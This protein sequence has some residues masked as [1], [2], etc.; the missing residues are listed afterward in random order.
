MRTPVLTSALIT[1]VLLS[2]LALGGCN[3]TAAP[4]APLPGAYRSAIT[5]PGFKLPEGTGCAGEIAR[6]RAVIGNDKRGGQVN[7]KVYDVITREIDGA[8]AS[9]S[10]GNE[11][12]AMNLVRASKSR[13][14]YPG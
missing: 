6:Y 1:G 3:T 11:A 7:D 5:P 2:S 13:H 8:S 4:P 12:Q 10:A 9:C 14:G